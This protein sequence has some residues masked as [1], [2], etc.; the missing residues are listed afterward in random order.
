MKSAQDAREYFADRY[1]MDVNEVLQQA[2]EENRPDLER[3]AVDA[4]TYVDRY[5]A[6]EYGQHPGPAIKARNVLRRALQEN[7][8]LS[9]W[10][11]QYA[12]GRES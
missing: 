8:A 10:E 6:G 3:F 9:A 12:F 7:R 5:R 2:R 4:L 11:Q 1:E